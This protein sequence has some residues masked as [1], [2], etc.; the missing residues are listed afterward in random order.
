MYPYGIPCFYTEYKGKIYFGHTPYFRIPYQNSIGD[1][2]DKNLK[3]DK[4]LDLTEAIFRKDKV[5]ATRVFFE[6]TSLKNEPKW[7]T[8]K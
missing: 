3:D 4:R 1:I 6:D 8:K 2:I 5:L 7:L